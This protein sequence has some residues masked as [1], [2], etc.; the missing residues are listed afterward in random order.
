MSGGLSFPPARITNVAGTRTLVEPA[1][2]RG[3]VEMLVLLADELLLGV[4][5][6]EVV[7]VEAAVVAL[8]TDE[9]VVLAEAEADDDE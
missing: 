5:A 6:A 3:V 2:E 1:L 8:A 9:V 7:L 4:P